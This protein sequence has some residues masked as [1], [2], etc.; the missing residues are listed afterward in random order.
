MKIQKVAVTVTQ[1][2]LED[3]ANEWLPEGYAL[4]RLRIFHAGILTS[5][6]TPLLRLDV[7]LRYDQ[8]ISPGVFVFSVEA[9]KGLKVPR[10]VIQMALKKLSEYLPNGI[11]IVDHR[12]LLSVNELL[13]P[14]VSTPS[15][16]L[17]LDDGVL[18]LEAE[19][20]QIMT[21]PQRIPSED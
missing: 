9:S 12:V 1:S 7:W 11:A 4:E 16:K 8:E 18:T 14:F 19:A 3:A 20:L 15:V 2:D 21:H 5:L 6:K 13:A 10:R 17:Q